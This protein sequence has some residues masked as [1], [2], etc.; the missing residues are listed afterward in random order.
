MRSR[1][2]LFATTLIASVILSGCATTAEA[3]RSKHEGTSEVYDISPDQAWLVAKI[4]LQWEDAQEVVEDKQ[5]GYITATVPMSGFSWGAVIAVWVDLFGKEYSKV[6]VVTKRK[7]QT[8]FATTLTETTFHR[9]FSQAV[10]IL[11]SGK[12][13]PAKAPQQKP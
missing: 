13:F 11:K 8:N 2:Y 12:P 7:M 3:L 10:E 6:T 5:A 9:E 4:V 1:S